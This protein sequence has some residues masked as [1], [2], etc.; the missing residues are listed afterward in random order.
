MPR[1][2]Q[3]VSLPHVRQA[4]HDIGLTLLSFMLYWTAYQGHELIQ[5]YVAYAQG[6]DLLFL[7]AGIKLVMIMVAGWRGAL[8]CGL[9]LLSVAPHF[10]P[11][12]DLAL[13]MLY[14]M[15]SVGITWLVVE[16]MLHH[17]GMEPT[18]QGLRFWD[19]VLIDAFNTMLHGVTI[20]LFFWACG[21]RSAELLWSATLGMALGDFLG[22]GAA[23]LLVLLAAQVLV[24]SRR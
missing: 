21:L 7:P 18:L 5:P 17:R 22:T 24:P 23:L 10:W 19:I 2:S 9:A 16:L 1:P 13:L 6:V 12:Q 3:L 8:G 14:A 11:E 4:A 15:L 20:N